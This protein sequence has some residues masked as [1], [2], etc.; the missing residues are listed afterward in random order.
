MSKKSHFPQSIE[1]MHEFRRCLLS[2]LAK[3]NNN[4]TLKNATE[5]IR[6]LMMEHITNQERMN[7]FLHCLQD[8]QND[9]KNTQKKE[10]IKVYGIAAEIFEESLIPFLPK[11][12]NH[13]TKRLSE[14]NNEIHVAY[15][16]SLGSIVHHVVENCTD[17]D[18]VETVLDTVFT[19]IFTQL[20]Q[21]SR[22][23]QQAASCCL[24][25]VVQNTPLESLLMKLPTICQS[26]LDTMQATGFKSQTQ[27]LESL[28]SLILSVEQEFEPY[29]KDFLP[30]LLHC[31]EN[32][33]W[34]T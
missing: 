20:N 32:S 7:T 8:Q 17:Y 2:S 16:E 3:F 25:K 33:D 1:N 34:N 31:V 10:Y 19:M 4:H 14:G 23:T 27:I 5:E 22:I 15:A 9:L 24:T 12:L 30:Q 21:P 26:I 11:I 18:Q 6:E 29:G 13:I 28:I